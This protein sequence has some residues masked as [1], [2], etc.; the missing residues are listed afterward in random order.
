ML[1]TTESI[2][3]STVS[4]MRPARSRACRIVTGEPRGPMNRR[5]T[6]TPAHTQV[7]SPWCDAPHSVIH[8]RSASTSLAASSRTG[9]STGELPLPIVMRN[10]PCASAT[11]TPGLRYTVV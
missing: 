1:A 10:A 8:C 7:L 2:R 3:A 4:H 9:T 11:L 6:K 5:P